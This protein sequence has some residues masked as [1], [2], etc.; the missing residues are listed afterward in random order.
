LTCIKVFEQ[1]VTGNEM[2]YTLIANIYV[3]GRLKMR[4]QRYVILALVLLATATLLPPET[5]AGGRH[6]GNWRGHGYGHGHGHGY[7]YGSSFSIGLGF[8]FPFYPY[9]YPY[10]YPYYAPAPP[11]YTAPVQLPPVAV[12]ADQSPYTASREEAAYCREYT[13]KIIVEGR[14]EIAY[15]TACLQDNGSWRIMN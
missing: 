8:V 5:Y 15:G 3:T 9:S 7:N 2:H 6:H 11:V 1:V 12:I 4:I 13:K 14:E 10:N